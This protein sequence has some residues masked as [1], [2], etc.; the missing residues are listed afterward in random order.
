M[1]A[2]PI[3][4]GRMTAPNGSRTPRSGQARA[5]TGQRVNA[6]EADR[7]HALARAAAAEHDAQLAQQE[8]ARAQA[9]AARSSPR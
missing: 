7:D 2:Y 3:V 5:E 4:L 9:A 8:A 1:F 6:A